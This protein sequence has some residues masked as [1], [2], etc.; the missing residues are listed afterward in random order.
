VGQATLPDWISAIAA[1]ITSVVAVIL[2]QQ[3]FVAKHQLSL[4]KDQL[5]QGVHWNKLSTVFQLF[6]AEK[7]GELERN[8]ARTLD[9]FDIDLYHKQDPLDQQV[10]EQILGNRDHLYSV[11]TFLNY[12]ERISAAVNT[13]VADDGAA[14]ALLGDVAIRY[15]KVFEPLVVSRAA[16]IG[17]RRALQELGLRAEQWEEV[18]KTEADAMNQL[19]KE[20]QQEIKQLGQRREDIEKEI[21]RKMLELGSYKGRRYGERT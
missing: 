13:G 17:N 16:E 4:A 19:D 6:D 2:I 21:Q 8:A 9:E 14:Y 11:K 18:R 1:I 20:T 12:L 10:A 3:L 7:F 5:D 15:N